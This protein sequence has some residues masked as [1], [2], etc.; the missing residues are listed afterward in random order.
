MLVA[1]KLCSKPLCA[2]CDIVLA[3]AATVI[4]RENL[5]VV[6]IEK[7]AIACRLQCNA[8]PLTEP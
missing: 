2:P 6:S 7:C 5:P 1:L 8:E 3:R 4:Y